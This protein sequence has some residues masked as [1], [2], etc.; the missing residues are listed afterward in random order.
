[1]ERAIE[2]AIEFLEEQITK[3]LDTFKGYEHLSNI[4]NLNS[5]I[6]NLKAYKEHK[7][8]GK[9]KYFE[10]DQEFNDGYGQCF[11]G[12]YFPNWN[13]SSYNKGTDFYCSEFE[14]KEQ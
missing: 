10:F 4:K 5:T 7:T 8:C 12:I 9:C 3:E 14:P 11:W 2:E 1:M 6:K 13:S